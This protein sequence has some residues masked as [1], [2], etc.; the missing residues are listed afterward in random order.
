MEKKNVWLNFVSES[1]VHEAQGPKGPFKNVSFD[2]EDSANGIA[3]VSVNMGQVRQS[4]KKDGTVAAGYVN[5]L[6]GAEGSKRQV[7]VKKADGSYDRV[8]MTVEAIANSF[9]SGREAYR[10]AQAAAAPA[11]EPEVETTEATK[12]KKAGRKTT[13]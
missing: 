4:T 5:V 10:A 12:V 3:T 11:V 7:S 13:K 9:A 6:L 1:M 2:C 8:E